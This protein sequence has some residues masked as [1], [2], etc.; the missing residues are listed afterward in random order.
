MELHALRV[1]L[2]EQDANDL[3]RRYMPPDSPVED[4]RV[5]LTPEGLI[6]TGQYPFFIAVKF[7]T[8]WE[9]GVQQGHV[10]ARLA[11]FRAMGVPGNIFKSAIM[12]LV[13]DAAR[14]EDWVRIHGDVI[15]ADAERGYAKYATPVRL[16]LRAITITAGQLTVEA[17][18][19]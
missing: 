2:T 10:F 14:R 1:S 8:V 19:G 9:L 18:G 7:E 12:K 6:V 17:G 16:N 13:E 5:Q 15:L 11:R 3:I 4:V